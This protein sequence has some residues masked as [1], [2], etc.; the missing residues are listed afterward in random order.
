MW[1]DYVEYNLKKFLQFLAQA[2][3]H[4]LKFT[5][6]MDLKPILFLDMSQADG[7]LQKKEAHVSNWLSSKEKDGH[8]MVI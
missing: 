8:C 5:I 4:F 6:V 2:Y 7:I 1:K 3:F